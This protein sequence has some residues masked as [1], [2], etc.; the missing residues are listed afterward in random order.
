MKVYH[1]FAIP[2]LSIDGTSLTRDGLNALHILVLQYDF[3]PPY[4]KA[5]G[6]VI[7]LRFQLTQ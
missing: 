7:R 4:L 1:V 5:I 6:I 2:I 3:F